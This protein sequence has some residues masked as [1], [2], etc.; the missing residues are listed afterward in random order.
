MSFKRG[1]II[2]SI[3]DKPDLSKLQ[4]IEYSKR[5]YGEP[6][7]I[8]P[9]ELKGIKQWDSVDYIPK[10][11]KCA[12]YIKGNDVW[13]KH[14]DYFSQEMKLPPEDFGMPLEVLANKY[15]DKQ[16]KNKFI[17]PDCWGSIVLRM[18]HGYVLKTLLQLLKM[19]SLYLTLN[20]KYFG[21][22]RNT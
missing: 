17:Y 2:R 3:F 20:Q 1:D 5:F 21:K 14:R 15:C 10:K 9:K 16:K 11:C 19:E 18:K 6:K 8:L 4:F 12:I 22:W 13:I 7:L